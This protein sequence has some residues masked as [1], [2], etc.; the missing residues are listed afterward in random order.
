MTKFD[1]G[2]REGQVVPNDQL[3]QVF[4]CSG[5]GGMRRARRTNSLILIS[6]GSGGTYYDRW[7]GKVLHYTGMGLV[8]DQELDYAQNKT[9][10]ESDTNGVAVFLFENPEP[11]H[12]VYAGPVHLIGAPYA[13]QQA[14]ADD[15]ERRVWVFPLG[16]GSVD[17]GP[18]LELSV[19]PSASA[20]APD[21]QGWWAR[22]I[23]WLRR[24]V[25]HE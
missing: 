24:L 25:R 21:R 5:Q 8:G 17:N 13:E 20:P 4:K 14:D 19:A 16:V 6:K 22:T 11:N 23:S 10:A 15:N 1:P 2:L 3:Q 7:D 12:Y 9:L 18:Q